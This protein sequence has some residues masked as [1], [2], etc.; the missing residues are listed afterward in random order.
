MA[1]FENVVIRSKERLMRMGELGEVLHS[2]GSKHCVIEIPEDED[3]PL[4]YQYGKGRRPGETIN[5]LPGRIIG[6]VTNIRI[7]EK[8]DLVG[9]V[10]I[11]P[12]M[13]LSAHYQGVIDNI[14]VG[15]TFP[16]EEE[17][18]E[19]RESRPTYKLEQLI[20]YD[21]EFVSEQK[22]KEQEN[23][24]V[25]KTYSV[26]HEVYDAPPDVGERLKTVLNNAEKE[27]TDVL[28]EKGW[29]GKKV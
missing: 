28:N 10:R 5:P 17:G 13:R 9:D 24:M 14:L 19:K 25:E 8:G 29:K 11:I 6:G 22:R 21:K 1:R 4:V 26:P 16:L 7:D 12:M 20:V 3:V 27:L 23:R 18:K 15:K 2:I